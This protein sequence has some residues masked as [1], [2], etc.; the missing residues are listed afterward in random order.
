MNLKKS[1]LIMTVI[2]L[3]PAK[4]IFAGSLNLPDIREVQKIALDYAR[5]RPDELTDLKKRTRRAAA[6]PHIQI[7]AKR[8]MQNNIDIAI[9]DNVSVTSS[10]TS[11]GPETS[12]IQQDVNNDTSIEVK[13]V[14]NLN[15]LIFN[16]DML[17]VAEEARFQM[18]ERRLLISEVNKLY[19]E[20][21]RLFHEKPISK[22]PLLLLKIQKNEI[23]ANLDSLTGG[24][25]SNQLAN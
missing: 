20:L 24:W 5:I 23:I 14:W 3:T 7:G 6:L 25:F 17:D 19:F 16:R 13:A 1:I 21:E 9:N 15:E 18:R 10:G 8:V 11:I 4:Y 2:I 12:D 22:N